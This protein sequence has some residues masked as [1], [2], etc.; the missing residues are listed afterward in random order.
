MTGPKTGGRSWVLDRGT[1]ALLID[2]RKTKTDIHIRC[3]LVLWVFVVEI[4][5]RNV[6]VTSNYR[7]AALAFLFYGNGF[8]WLNLA[9]ADGCLP[10]E[11][12]RIP[13]P[14]VSLDAA[15]SG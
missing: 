4:S 3:D 1:T 8:A 9:P 15:K 6:S 5:F 10:K 2:N 14:I 11:R 12:N 7:L 13:G